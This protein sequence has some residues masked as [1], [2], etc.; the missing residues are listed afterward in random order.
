MPAFA[1]TVRDA[2]GAMREGTSEAENDGVLARRL[3]EQGYTIVNIEQRKA[4][5]AR[6]KGMGF[7]RV[8][9]SDLSMFCRQFSTMVDAGVSLVRCLNVL[10]EQTVNPKLRRIIAQ[11]EEDV[12]SGQ[13]LS[14]SMGKYPGVFDSLFIGL[15]RAGE[16]GGALEDSLQ[17]LSGFLEKDMELKRKVKGAMTYPTIVMIVA[18]LIVLG[19]V[20]FI[21]P[22]FMKMFTDMGIKDFPALTQGLMDL[23]NFIIS[24]WYIMLGIVIAAVVSLK[25]F[26][27]TRVGSR[28]FDRI[29][30]KAP[31]FGPLNHKVS[32]SRFAR[33]L[34]TLLVSGVPIL[35]ALE[36]VAGTV[37]NEIMSDAILEARARIREGDRIGDPLKK[38]NLFPPMVVQMISIGEES[39]A[40][41]HMLG[42]VADFY[43]Q[44]V[45]AA[46]E[47]LT[48][49][50]EPLMIVFLGTVVGFIVVAMFMPMISLISNL[51]GGG[52]D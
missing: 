43:E 7:G 41:D 31:V 37:S 42:K 51:S 32:L 28:I 3:Q 48:A 27:R 49:A 5:K 11:I 44:E 15:I 16:I 40:L 26:G 18:V 30:L 6:S 8:K 1:Y 4:V 39:G 20:T 14:K 50:I 46:V 19:L 23:S 21:L 38:S 34:S 9:L 36:T 47:S 45:D 12:Q 13:T 52:G 22:K 35:S 25:L 29:K 2:T 24:K 17:R 33:T 10:G